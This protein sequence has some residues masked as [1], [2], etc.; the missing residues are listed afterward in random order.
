[1]ATFIVL[2]GPPGAGKGTQA[3]LA[4]VKFNLITIS[5]GDL[6]REHL[7]NK[8][9]LGLEAKK[10]MDLGEL[11]PDKI[12]VAMIKERLALPDAT[13]GAILDGFPRSPDQ[14]EALDTMLRETGH[15]VS[16]AIS[17]DANPDVVI[18][19]MAA[20]WMCA[21]VDGCGAIYNTDTNPPNVPGICP[22]CGKGLIQ[23]SDDLD[24]GAISRRIEIY[25]ENIDP[26][27]CFYEKTGRIC[28]FNG[29]DKVE[30]VARN[31]NFVL[32]HCIGGTE[33]TSTD[34]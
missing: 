22:N 8:T 12:T 18:A 9:P 34:T 11:V 19:R 33:G 1:M 21:G 29:T 24:Q 27:L 14:A 4:A 25:Q 23:R 26:L 17:L 2:L 5:S 20:R 15:S 30:V 10:Y 16:A 6:F 28:S 13:N 31:I 32:S 7:K 3:K